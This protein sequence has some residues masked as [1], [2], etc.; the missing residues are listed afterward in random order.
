MTLIL[1]SLLLLTQWF[2]IPL[3]TPT[4]PI[5]IESIDLKLKDNEFA[6]TFFSLSDGEAA[7]IH[8]YNG[9]N[10]LLNPG[11][12]G[13]KS[14]LEELFQLYNV[15]KISSII[16]TTDQNI[17]NVN[18]IVEKYDVQKVIA[19]AK[20]LEKIKTEG[21]LAGGVPCQIWNAGIKEE[22]Y[23][24]LSF[25]VLDD[26]NG[27][28]MTIKFLNKRIIWFNSYGPG[29]E[30]LMSYPELTDTNFVKLPSFDTK[31]IK[32]KEFIKYFDPQIAVLYYHKGVEPNREL[33]TRL[34]ESWAD[35][36]YTKDQDTVTIKFTEENYD[37]FTL[38]NKKK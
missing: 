31:E 34:A 29:S 38:S 17:E 5:E 13:T 10:V 7:L 33:L 32:I 27:L 30:K 23:P 22:L 36:F 37:V 2:Y 9:E 19:G 35:V 15:S 6:M 28:D 16:L 14:E 3:E 1:A 24:G 4:K 8:H 20:T 25:E 12:T 18:W 21:K 11:G 26:Q